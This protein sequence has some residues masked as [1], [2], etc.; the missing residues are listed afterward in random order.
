[1]RIVYITLGIFVLLN[2]GVVCRTPHPVA[3]N[4]TPVSGGLI[5]CTEE[6]TPEHE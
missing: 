5:H 3:E 1:M 4:C 2:I 6:K